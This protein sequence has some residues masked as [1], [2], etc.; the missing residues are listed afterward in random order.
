MPQAQPTAT[1]RND[2]NRRRKSDGPL[3]AFLS[4]ITVPLSR[5]YGRVIAMR[6]AR[7]DRGTGVVRF[8]RPVISIGNITTGGT[9]KTPMTAWIARQLMAQ[10]CKPVIAMRGYAAK[11]GEMSDEQA[12]YREL[13]PD[14]DV[15]AA[16]DRAAALR[17]YLPAHPEAKC[18]LL[19][20]GFQHR[21]IHRDLD[22]VLLDAGADTF[23]Q[24]MLPAGHLREP[25]VNLNR[26][27]AVIVTH[28]DADFSKSEVSSLRSQIEELLGK[29]PVAWS[30]HQWIE[31]SVMT[32]DGQTQIQSA[33]WL[34]NKR[35]VTMLGIGRPSSVT[36]E[37]ERRGA[38]IMA[39]IPAADHERFDRAK[40]TTA[41]G[42][43]DGCDALVATAK[44][45]VKLRSLIDLEHWPSA[46][47]VP[48]LEI[49]V[50]DGESALKELI[51]A[52]VQVPVSQV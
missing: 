40:V 41:R 47:I 48:R 39:N 34:R 49:D 30:R 44:D 37:L 36:D 6:N 42:L 18:I 25:L 3:P 11:S 45:W 29:S 2:R 5:A 51:L 35:V 1:A 14:V 4:P 26:A 50:F 28:A 43:C 22:L 27:D 20:D 9:G 10:G 24:R 31:L 17:E 19:D 38:R 13:L 23:N 15:L 46:I 52:A 12:E 16:P 33:S 8:D 32:S 21:Q 7:F